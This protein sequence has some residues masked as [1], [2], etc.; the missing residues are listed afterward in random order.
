LIPIAHPEVIMPVLDNPIATPAAR[1]PSDR[2]AAE[3]RT[4]APAV[5]AW[6][7]EGG[8]NT[9]WVTMHHANFSIPLLT[10]MRQM[11]DDVV[12]SGVAWP[13]AGAGNLPLNYVV[14]K[15]GDA[16]YFNLGGDLQYFHDCIRRGAADDL[17]R[18][19]ML[20]LDMVYEWGTRLSE[21][22]T[23]VSLVQGRALGGGFE[24]ALSSDVLIAEEGSQFGFPEIMFGTFPCTGAMSLLT[25]RLPA[26]QAEVMMT[27][28]KIYT[29][30]ELHDMGVVDCL[31]PKG[32][33]FEATEQFIRKHGMQR[34]A[35]LAVQRAR[36]REAPLVYPVLEAVVDDW[37]RVATR[38]N[39]QQ[40]RAMEI[41]A[42]MQRAA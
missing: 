11:L 38:L 37:V 13:A 16:D 2:H 4:G 9:L 18:Y 7:E 32:A 42:R 34:E 14:L 24:A 15:S 22:A 8:S 36:H 10:Q 33:G 17:R 31:C 12:G 30:A 26:R 20:C 1:A 6:L 23:T 41:L 27:N 39:P 5:S 29:A 21:S 28:G 35:R 3:R 25:R 19:S 40:L